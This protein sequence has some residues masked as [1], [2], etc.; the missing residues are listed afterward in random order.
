[1]KPLDSSEGA[2]SVEGFDAEQGSALRSI[3]PGPGRSNAELSDPELSD[4][5]RADPEQA[6]F[7]VEGSGAGSE[8]LVA[9]TVQ[10]ASQVVPRGTAE[11]EL[12]D[13]PE[14]LRYSDVAPR[15][16]EES[17][18]V[19]DDGVGAVF[20]ERAA[21]LTLA[22][23]PLTAAEMR[24]V[25]AAFEVEEPPP[26]SRAPVSQSP[27]VAHVP[28]AVP[29]PDAAPPSEAFS[30]PEA[31]RQAEPVPSAEAAL[32]Q[33]I[34]QHETP[35]APRH[36]IRELRAAA[37]AT[38]LGTTLLGPA[39]GPDEDDEATMVDAGAELSETDRALAHQSRM[40]ETLPAGT[41]AP[42]P[43]H[44]A[45]H[46]APAVAP[47]NSHFF[48]QTMMLGLPLLQP[49]ASAA[50]S[51]P[52]LAAA[53]GVEA[54]AP[55]APAEDAPLSANGAVLASLVRV[56]GPPTQP[57]PRRVRR[58]GV[59]GTSI[60][61]AGTAA[62]GEGDLDHEAFSLSNPIGNPELS[63]RSSVPAPP[64]A[65]ADAGAAASLSSLLLPR[66][67][68]RADDALGTSVARS[69]RA[70]EPLGTPAPRSV[71]TDEA[72]GTSA[73]RSARA[74]GALGT[75][76]ARSARHDAAPGSSLPRSARADDEFGTSVAR[77]ARADEAQAA[78]S[79]RPPR[80]DDAFGSSAARV[81]RA[82]D[83]LGT[84]ARASR[85]DE[86][87]VIAPPGSTSSVGGVSVRS[88]SARSVELSQRTSY[89]PPL[90]ATI[91]PPAA[92]SRT[93]PPISRSAVAGAVP[94]EELQ[95]VD[96]F[97]GFIAP[98][99]SLAQRWLVVVVVALAVVGLCSLAAIAFGL[100][101][102]TGW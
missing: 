51:A 17:P 64:P 25:F 16:Q 21:A 88:L 26:L 86:G 32:D 97:S 67:G 48:K 87:F 4:P 46:R 71:R 98:A 14:V 83:P 15:P 44:P 65:S 57:P 9:G 69:A 99:P 7:G 43:A 102:K 42:A 73:P 6:E 56:V 1:M 100:L 49:P 52:A 78:P 31:S 53:P 70:D 90:Q 62:P 68:G 94:G 75:S 2:A 79:L 29:T 41:P 36:A 19:A 54:A 11:G 20:P 60:V 61:E 89:P 10:R 58:V 50:A 76:M 82:D 35:R 72:V 40:S 55:P 18:E 12:G 59:G 95:A 96:P 63:R 33:D 92:R 34:Q 77:S 93:R 39:F 66:P 38:D 28:E 23:E 80:A 3:A 37:R 74:D 8:V 101:G 30:A 24:E 85:S 91:E 27:E 5:E 13:E 81:V 47:D 84:S 22:S 45:A